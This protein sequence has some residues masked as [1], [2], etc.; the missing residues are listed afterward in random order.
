MGAP[1]LQ[2]YPIQFALAKLLAP[3]WHYDVRVVNHIHILSNYFLAVV[4]VFAGD[5]RQHPWPEQ[6]HI[7]AAG[8]QRCSRHRGGMYAQQHHLW[9]P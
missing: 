1:M 9:Y 5:L 7:F 6:D 2:I 4:I 8:Y 3:K